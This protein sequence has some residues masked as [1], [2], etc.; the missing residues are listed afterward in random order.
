MAHSNLFFQIFS[1]STNYDKTSTE[2]GVI[3]HLIINLNV[4]NLFKDSLIC[5]S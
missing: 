4:W 1:L 2:K 5:S 3:F